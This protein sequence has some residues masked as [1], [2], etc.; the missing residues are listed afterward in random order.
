MTDG[1]SLLLF[2][3]LGSTFATSLA[4]TVD[5]I[6]TLWSCF[7]KTTVCISHSEVTLIWW[8]F[9]IGCITL[10][11][12]LLCRLAW[13]L[14][15]LLR[16]GLPL[17]VLVSL[18]NYWSSCG[19]FIYDSNRKLHVLAVSICSIASQRIAIASHASCSSRSVNRRSSLADARQFHAVNF[20]TMTVILC[21]DRCSTVCYIAD[22]VTWLSFRDIVN[23]VVTAVVDTLLSTRWT[24]CFADVARIDSSRSRQCPCSSR[25][26]V[27]IHA[28]DM[29]S[30]RV[31]SVACYATESALVG[32]CTILMAHSIVALR[33]HWNLICLGYSKSKI[34]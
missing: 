23:A 26:P 27:A 8:S 15:R 1:P 30:V 25:I 28:A 14:Q 19:S 11:S 22:G 34:K 17:F 5:L 20:V 6:G 7:R 31:V 10:C 2:S 9:V 4:F 12:G 21:P 32:Q 13:L 29:A 18:D 24:V 33:C 3:D 16:I